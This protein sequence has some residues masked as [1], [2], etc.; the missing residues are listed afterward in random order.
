MRDTGGIP[1]GSRVQLA[2]FHYWVSLFE[3]LTKGGAVGVFRFR[4]KVQF[5]VQHLLLNKGK[6][7]E[8]N[9][10]RRISVSLSETDAVAAKSNAVARLPQNGNTP[11]CSVTV[12]V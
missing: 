6:F 1:A 4:G 10:Q 2:R 11:R 5:L 9:F 7:G 3:L 8:P 12:R